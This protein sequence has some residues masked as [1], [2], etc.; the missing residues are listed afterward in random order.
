[1]KTYVPTEEAH[2]GVIAEFRTLH[3]HM[4]TLAQAVSET[5][6]M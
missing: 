4:M 5:I 3:D 6:S 2:D 1:M